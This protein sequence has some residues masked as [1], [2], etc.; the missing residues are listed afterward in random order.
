VA[1]TQV[2]GVLIREASTRDHLGV[3]QVIDGANLELSAETVERRIDAGRVLVAD[4]DNRILGA[5]VAVARD[6]GA[7]VEAVAVRR[8]RRGQGLGAALVKAAAERWTPLTAEF[9]PDV[10][11]FYEHLGFSIE[12]RGERRWGVLE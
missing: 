5:L 7:H 3:M 6:E 11:P 1:T 8:R 10:R 4:D 2:D 12:E 9:D